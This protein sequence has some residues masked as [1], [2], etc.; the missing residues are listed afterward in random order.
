MKPSFDLDKIKFATDQPT[1]EKAVDLYESG[2][3]TRFDEGIGAYSAVVLG[4]RPYRVSI[5]ARRF[6]LGN[7]EC[8]LG[9]QDT[10]CKHMV[11][12]SICAVM[13]GK[14]LTKEDKDRASGPVCS[15]KLGELSKEDLTQTKTAITSAVKYI[16]PYN[17]PSRLW[18]SY[19]NSLDEGCARL[20]KI[21]SDLPVSEQTSALLVD[22]LL[23]LDKKLC[24]GGVDDSNG[25]VSGFMQDVVLMLQEYAKIDQKSIN[26]FEKLCG[27]ETCFGWEE[28][29]V[30]I[31]D[32]GL[33]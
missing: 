2:K 6:G 9:Q 30:R 13:D 17:G 25:T 3:V 16:K 21:V 7:C 18:F 15:G 28:P 31:V 10:L 32:E 24:T 23:R 27:K 26:T 33:S 14:K 11:A 5:E 22:L 12:L 20:G 1:Y 8:Y 4:S 19:Q 29:L